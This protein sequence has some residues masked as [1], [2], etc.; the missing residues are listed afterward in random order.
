MKNNLVR[1]ISLVIALLLMVTSFAG[2]KKDV[3]DT[4]SWD[5]GDF[6]IVEGNDSEND[7]ADASDDDN[8]LSSTTDPQNEVTSSKVDSSKTT[9]LSVS[10][11]MKN[12]PKKLRGTTLT[13]YFW[14]DLKNTQYSKAIAAWE[15]ETGI[16]FNTI[17]S[18]KSGYD[19]ELAARI[20]SGNSPDMFKCIYN[21]PTTVTNLQPIDASNFN[22]ND[23]AWDK[24]LMADFTFNG[25]TYAMQVKNSPQQNVN[26]IMYNKQALKKAELEDPY[27]IWKKDPSKW[28]WAKVWEMCGT[29][30]KRNG[31]KEGYYGMSSSLEESYLRCFNTGLYG[32]NS[33][34]GKFESYINASSSK[35]AKAVEAYKTL[36]SMIEKNYHAPT[37]DGNSFSMGN[38]LFRLTFSSYCEKAQGTDTNKYGVVPIPTDSTSSSGFEYCAYG[39]P[40]GAKNPEAVPYFVRYVFCP[41]IYSLDNFYMNAQAKEVVEYTVNKGNICYD[42]GWTWQVWDK[43]LK[44]DSTQVGTVIDS[45]AS[46]VDAMVATNNEYIKQF[47]K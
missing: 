27:Q 26:I 3:G 45:Y 10:E 23:T 33:K 12:I 37:T 24:E 28:T 15:K 9:S 41:E 22:F 19:S 21:R 34:T 7:K 20:A 16:K 25:K 47:A 1:V 43:L 40:K 18:T 44:S 6:T 11:V 5:M 8:T 38:T 14:E 2:C 39:I 30:L 36:F 31:N 46:E 42:T 17:I 29:F 35:K 4:E 32:Y 13:F